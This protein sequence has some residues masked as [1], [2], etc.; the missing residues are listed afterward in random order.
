[1]R[2]HII[3]QPLGYRQPLVHVRTRRGQF[4]QTPTPYA[5]RT[6]N[7]RN[8]TMKHKDKQ[9]QVKTIACEQYMLSP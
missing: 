3:A 9:R 8:D 2:T 4:S 7:T 6:H 5:L 1:M